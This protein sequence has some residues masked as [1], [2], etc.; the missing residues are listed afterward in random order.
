MRHESELKLRDEYATAGGDKRREN[1]KNYANSWPNNH[2]LNAPLTPR[3]REEPG[4]E[5]ARSILSDGRVNRIDSYR[6]LVVLLLQRIKCSSSA[7]IA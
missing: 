2:Q 5:T 6:S 3:L 4:I 7:G 1:E